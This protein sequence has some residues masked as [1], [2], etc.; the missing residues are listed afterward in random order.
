MPETRIGSRRRLLEADRRAT[1]GGLAGAGLAHQA[2]DFATV[3]RQRHLVDGAEARLAEPAGELDDEIVDLQDRLGV[4]RHRLGTV[5]PAQVG[6]SL[7]QGPRVRVRRRGEQLLDGGLLDHRAAIHDHDPIGHVGDDAHVVGDQD[8]R[9][10]EPVAQRQQQLEDRGL[11]RHVERR[12]GLVGDD[13]VGIGRDRHGDDDA[14]LL[15]AGQLVR[16]VVDPLGG[17]GHA[18]Q[19]EQL[20]GAGAGRLLGDRLPWARRPSTICQPTV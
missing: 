18:H 4:G 7:E 3:H 17:I 5:R 10:A 11:H 15:T 12:G 13:H 6:D 16:V 20:D 2:Q 8:D 19:L 14:L 1:D 9:G